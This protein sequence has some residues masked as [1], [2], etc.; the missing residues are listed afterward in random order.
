MSGRPEGIVGTPNGRSASHWESLLIPDVL[1]EA[2]QT[3]DEEKIRF[4]IVINNRTADWV[5]S[6]A[7]VS[8]T[9]FPVSNSLNDV[10]LKRLQLECNAV[11]IANSAIIIFDFNGNMFNAP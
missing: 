5:A 11:L 4:A 8:Q 2:I 1:S 7:P 6:T 9:Y 3:P 10:I